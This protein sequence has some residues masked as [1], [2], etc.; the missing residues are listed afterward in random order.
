MNDRRKFIGLW[1]AVGLLLCLNLATIAWIL[2][3]AKVVRTNRQHPE[4]LLVER[5][6]FTSD[7]HT[8]YQQLRADF[9]QR[10]QPH[11]DSL[12]LIRNA[13]LGQLAQPVP[14]A[15]LSRLANRMERQYGQ[16]AQLRFRHWQQVRALCTP[17]QQSRFDRMAARILKQVPL[18]PN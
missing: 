17:R 3:R 4:M 16:L 12:R 18:K 2:N 8:R 1:V 11:Q 6:N 9:E 14:D 5:L 10:S 13:L 15:E 7:Q